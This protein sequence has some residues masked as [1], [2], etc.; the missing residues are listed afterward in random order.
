MNLTDF[1][2]SIRP[3][4]L[5]AGW[6]RILCKQARTNGFKCTPDIV[7]DLVFGYD[8]TLK[9]VKFRNF[10]YF[11]LLE[12]MERLKYPTQNLKAAFAEARGVTVADIEAGELGDLYAF[13][14]A[15]KGKTEKNTTVL[16]KLANRN[17]VPNA[18][19]RAVLLCLFKKIED[20]KTAE[21]DAISL[22][23]L[24]KEENR[25]KWLGYACVFLAKNGGKSIKKDAK[26]CE[27]NITGWQEYKSGFG[28]HYG[29]LCWRFGSLRI[30][31]DGDSFCVGGEVFLT[32]DKAKEYAITQVRE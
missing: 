15:H 11:Y 24:L 28:L 16:L 22:D 1:L 30:L 6:A 32:L 25:V 10:D 18:T 26:L 17:G 14:R 12:R 4:D 2:N 27:P 20:K 7:K 3:P 21:A 31:Q 13:C 19:K 9:F 8:D 29:R 23:A 5:R